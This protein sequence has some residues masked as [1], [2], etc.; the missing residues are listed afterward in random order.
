MKKIKLFSSYCSDEQIYNNIVGSWGKGNTSYKDFVFTVNDDYTHAVLFNTAMHN[1]S[2]NPKNVIGFSHEPRKILGIDNDKNYIN[3][4]A[5]NVSAYYISNRDNLPPNFI[6]GN[7]FICPSEFKESENKSYS[8][9]NRMS[10]ILSMKMYMPGHTMR[11]RILKEILKTD[12]DIHFFGNGVDE[13]YNDERVKKFDWNI[14]NIPYENYKYQIVVENIIDRNWISEKLT[15]CII[16]ET[17]PIYYGSEKAIKE[18]YPDNSII[19]LNDNL[20]ENVAKIID[21]YNKTEN[22]LTTSF[23]KNKLYSENN[24]LEFIYLKFKDVA[25]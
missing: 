24:L 15:N 17:I 18:Y 4:V 25:I 16:K 14:F 11:H 6:E 7:T 12:L 23:A 20:K 2:L 21:L 8:H 10:M 1:K 3:F 22:G 19:I 5:N 13:V 9:E